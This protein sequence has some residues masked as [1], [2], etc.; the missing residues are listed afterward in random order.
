MLRAL[1][2]D[3]QAEAYDYPDVYEALFYR[4]NVDMAR[5]IEDLLKTGEIQFVVVGA[6]HLV[7]DRG[8][9]ELLEKNYSVEQ[10]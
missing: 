5:K 9:V 3:V 8:I 10:R 1:P 6:G 4:R 2:Q 7:G